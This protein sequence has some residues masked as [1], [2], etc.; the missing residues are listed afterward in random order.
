MRFL[1][2]PLNLMACWL[3]LANVVSAQSLRFYVTPYLAHEGD[4]VRFIYVDKGDGS[5]IPATNILHWQWDFNGD[6]VVNV[7][8]IFAFL[9]AFFAQNG[10]TGPGHSADFNGDGVVNV[11]DV[12]FFLHAW[13]AGCP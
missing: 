8:D 11:F 3:M 1:R 5:S 13:F 10:Q 9:A 4:A 7:T 2:L 12:F 6:N